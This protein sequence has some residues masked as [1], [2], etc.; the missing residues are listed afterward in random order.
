MLGT[1]IMM[2]KTSTEVINAFVS[3]DL[4]WNFRVLTDSI[5]VVGRF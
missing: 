1:A 4:G 5:Q 3:G 2:G